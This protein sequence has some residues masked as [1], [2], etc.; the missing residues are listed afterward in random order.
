[1]YLMYLLRNKTLE[2]ELELDCDI[3]N[4]FDKSVTLRLLNVHPCRVFRVA[5]CAYRTDWERL[6]LQYQEQRDSAGDGRSRLQGIVS[7][8][9]M[10]LLREK[11]R[12]NV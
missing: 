3:I 8:V 5:L 1:M 12:K 11:I 4:M 7:C 9:A 10:F 6:G 2:L